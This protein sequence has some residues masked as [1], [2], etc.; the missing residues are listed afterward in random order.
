MRVTAIIPA[1]NEEGSIGAVVSGLLQY[2]AD[3]VVVVDNGST[4]ST[5]GAAYE[6]GARVVTEDRRGYGSACLAGIKA[7]EETDIVV[8]ADGDGCDDPAD[9]PSLLQAL[10]DGTA[11]MVIGSRNRGLAEPGALPPHSRFGNWLASLLL[12][13]LY[14]QRVTDLGPFRAVKFQALRSLGMKDTGYGWTVEMQAKAALLGLT[15]AEV[16]VHYRKRAAGK[17]KIT[18]NLRASAIAGCV[19]LRTLFSIRVIGL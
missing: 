10:K 7:I 15:V 2:G 14:G 6:A 16:P 11:D 3:E 8:F 19:I 5:A 1:L 18:G 13:L 9:L 17:S 12:R 4:D